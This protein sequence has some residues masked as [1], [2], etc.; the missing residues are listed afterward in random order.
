MVNNHKIIKQVCLLYY[1]NLFYTQAKIKTKILHKTRKLTI[2]TIYNTKINII[3]NGWANG[4][5]G[6]KIYVF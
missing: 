1:F 6:Y 5:H 3:A 2:N 4:V